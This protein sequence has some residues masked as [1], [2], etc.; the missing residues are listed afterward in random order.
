MRFKLVFLGLLLLVVIHG[1]LF[2]KNSFSI[3]DIKNSDAKDLITTNWANTNFYLLDI[4]TLEEYESYYLD[5]PRA[6]F[7][8]YYHSNFIQVLERLYTNNIYLL[9]CHGGYRSKKTIQKIK[10][11][12]L[13]FKKIYH[14]KKGVKEWKRV[15]MKLH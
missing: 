14:L 4:R 11:Q 15:N 1:Q 9:Y 2:S 12:K 8:D 7:V 3:V 13:H 6:I 10:K 5:F